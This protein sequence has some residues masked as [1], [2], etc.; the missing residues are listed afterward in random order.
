[1]FSDYLSITGAICLVRLNLVA[2]TQLESHESANLRLH[3]LGL[4]ANYLEAG[5]VATEFLRKLME[6]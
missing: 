1:M 5:Q 2:M 4:S 6:S 3:V